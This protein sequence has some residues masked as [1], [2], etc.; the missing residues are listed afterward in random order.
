M[1]VA[2]VPLWRTAEPEAAAEAKR[3]VAGAIGKR[4]AATTA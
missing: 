2:I 1:L 3:P 4:R